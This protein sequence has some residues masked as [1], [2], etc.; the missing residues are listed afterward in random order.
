M[1]GVGLLGP[2][3]IFPPADPGFPGRFSVGTR[4]FDVR[5]RLRLDQLVVEERSLLLRNGMEVTILWRERD[6]AELPPAPENALAT[7][8]SAAAAASA[9]QGAVLTMPP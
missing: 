8:A 1:D 6:R 5:G 9:S 3:P 7:A 4:F 2:P